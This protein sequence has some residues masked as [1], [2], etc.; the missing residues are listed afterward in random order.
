MTI[1][2]LI[3]GA[4][5]I[6]FTFQGKFNPIIW[7]CQKDQCTSV[8]RM[9]RWEIIGLQLATIGQTWHDYVLS[10]ISNEMFVDIGYDSFQGYH[11]FQ[12]GTSSKP[13]WRKQES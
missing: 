1:Q 13:Y 10:T 3:I 12:N 2:I 4:H 5:G 6:H 8:I 9:C 7:Y 11:I